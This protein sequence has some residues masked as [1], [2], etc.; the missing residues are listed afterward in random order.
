MLREMGECQVPSS[1]TS[2]IAIFE[3]VAGASRFED[4]LDSARS[5]SE[6]A[7]EE[8]L[9]RVAMLW[10]DILRIRFRFIAQLSKS[11]TARKSSR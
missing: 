5:S 4:T 7:V 10:V 11:I 8:R 3:A 2:I 6:R 9:G 1:R